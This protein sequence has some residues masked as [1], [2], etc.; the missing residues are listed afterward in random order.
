MG[1]ESRLY[2]ADYHEKTNWMDV[3]ASFDLCKLYV[4]G[5][6]YLFKTPITNEV[7]LGGDDSV[8]EDMYGEVIKYA[9][10]D[11]VAKFLEENCRDLKYRRI[12]PCISLLRSFDKSEWQN[13]KVLHYGH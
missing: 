2:I 3:I 8:M 9:D 11:D 6:R 4:D 10:I 1:Y 13:L 5:W 12:E 7:F